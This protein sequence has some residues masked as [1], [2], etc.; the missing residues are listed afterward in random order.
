MKKYS[1]Q[2]KN[3][4]MTDNDFE[5]RVEE[6]GKAEYKRQKKKKIDRKQKHQNDEDIQ[7]LFENFF[8]KKGIW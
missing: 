6:K 5:K 4:L 3:R 1:E 2:Y 7:L 8:G